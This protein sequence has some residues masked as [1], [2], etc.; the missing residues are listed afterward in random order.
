MMH[1]K[2]RSGAAAFAVLALALTACSPSTGSG[3]GGSTTDF[4]VAGIG[5]YASDPF[6]IT[7]M[8]GA[9]QYAD[10][11]GLDFAWSAPNTNSVPEQQTNLDAALL[12][13]PDGVLLTPGAADAFSTQVGELMAE[14]TPVVTSNIGLNPATELQNFRSSRDNAEFIDYVI[15]DI[16]EDAVIGV[17]GGIA[18]GSEVLQARWR[19]LVEQ[20]NAEHPGVTV[21]E[22]E[23]SEFDRNKATTIAAAMITAHPDLTAIYSVA[24][25]E[26]EGVAAAVEEAGKAGDISIYAYDA[27]PG[28]VEL[29]RAGTITALISQPAGL[30]GSEGLKA[31]VEYLEATPD[32]GAVTEQSEQV[33]VPLRVLTAE[34]IDDPESEPYIYKTE[35]TA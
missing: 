9:T 22:T 18:G 20:L 8:C 32:G 16:G 3:D 24:G 29:L 30:L 35:C 11:I 1:S 25:P 5:N 19:P 15:D 7:L 14:G 2:K 34:N 10:E 13:G 17:L 21:L 23:Y 31:L 27:T 28:E 4:T 12:G 33:E 26:A 6:Y